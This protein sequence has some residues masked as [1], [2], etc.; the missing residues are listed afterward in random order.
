M[1]VGCLFRSGD[2]S[3]LGLPEY[4]SEIIGTILVGAS[5]PFFQCSPPLLSGT[6][7]G[8]DE[9]ALSTSI[10]LN[11]NQ[12]GIATAFVVGGFFLGGQAVSESLDQYLTI[13][14]GCAFAAFAATVALF[15][16]RPPPPPTASAAKHIAEQTIHKE[17]AGLVFPSTVQKLLKMEGFTMPLAAFVCSIGLTNV[18]STF[19]S[20]T[21]ERAGFTEASTI[22]GIGAAFQVAIMAGGIILGGYVDQTKRFK[23]VTLGC[24][25]GAFAT[26]M[27]LGVAEGNE[28][29]LPPAVV[30]GSLVALGAFAGPIQPI[31]AE[32]AVEVS[33]PEDECA[34]EAT[35]Q[36]SGNLFSALLVPI[37]LKAST[38]DWT[39]NLPL[40][41]Q[42]DMK[43]DSLVLLGL[44]AATA[45]FFSTFK[46]ELRREAADQEADPEHVSHIADPALRAR[47]LHLDEDEVVAMM[48]MEKEALKA[49]KEAKKAEKAK[50][51][52]EQ[53][54]ADK[55]AAK[56]EIKVGE[57]GE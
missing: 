47:S 34:V 45:A 28:V 37:C 25:G 29:T 1:A 22:I 48:Q 44:T 57:K 5:Q 42:F 41:Q 18:V 54:K 30:I 52:E 43:G 51:A 26:L 55:V 17:D 4:W 53:K 13:I 35:Q 50:E 2:P 21:M 19:T 56:E 46:G 3:N 33:Y 31:N 38:L 39:F 15:K 20:E 11:A 10:C 49:Q 23:E 32:L 16:E 8:Q 6:W 36:L 27:L 40:L 12:L 24:F 7:F 9:R 14:T